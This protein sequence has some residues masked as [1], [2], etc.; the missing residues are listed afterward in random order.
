LRLDFLI[1]FG[2]AAVLVLCIWQRMARTALPGPEPQYLRRARAKSPIRFVRKPTW[3]VDEIVRLK[4]INPRY[5]VRK[6]EA[7]FNRIHGH[8][9][10]VSKSYVAN[11]VCEHAYAITIKRWEIK[12]RLPRPVA[13]NRRWGLDGTG[14]KLVGASLVNILGI[15]DHGSRLALCMEVITRLNFKAIARALLTTIV[16][17]GKPQAIRTDNASQF[18][19][20]RFRKLLRQ[21]GIAHERTAPSCPW[22]NGHVERLFGTLKES[23]N[24]LAVRDAQALVLLLRQFC[25]WYNC[26]R[27]HQHLCGATPYEA[28][29][30]ADIR[31]PPKA[32]RYFSVWD[33]LLTGF[34]LRR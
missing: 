23:L 26:V 13:V 9:M 14:K 17:Y 10:T 33:G 11:V 20:K 28:W 15:V 19:S 6:I 12:H 4:A 2:I 30:G 31:Q 22:M 8:L 25:F 16:E 29:T 24:L 18:T 32:A 3:V 27:P 1:E 5:G 21:L 34:Y 7:L